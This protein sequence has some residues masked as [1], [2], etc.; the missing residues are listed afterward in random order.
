MVVPTLH[1]GMNSTN[2]MIAGAASLYGAGSTAA[3]FGGADVEATGT[4]SCYRTLNGWIMKSLSNASIAFQSDGITASTDDSTFHWDSLKRGMI[5]RVNIGQEGDPTK[6]TVVQDN[7]LGAP[8]AGTAL[9]ELRRI[10]EI[11]YADTSAIDDGAAEGAELHDGD[12]FQVITVPSGA[13]SGQDTT[14]ASTGNVVT[15]PRL[16]YVGS[17]LGNNTDHDST[18]AYYPAPAWSYAVRNDGNKLYRIALSECNDVDITSANTSSTFS[19]GGAT[20]NTTSSTEF[21]HRVTSISLSDVIYEG[22]EIGTIS[23]CISTDGEGGI[24]G[25]TGTLKKGFISGSGH[26]I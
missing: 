2:S 19:T 15:Y 8:A 13:A 14:A 11:G 18:N 24:S 9:N 1:S 4:L 20:G 23:N 17:L 26:V 3:D 12:L 6:H 16:I 22:F 7:T 21:L 25:R 5:F 10:K